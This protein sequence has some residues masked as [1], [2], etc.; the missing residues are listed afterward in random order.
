MNNPLFDDGFEG[1]PGS[2]NQPGFGLLLPPQTNQG[3][4][5]ANHDGPASG[6]M[7]H[8]GPTARVNH[9]NRANHGRMN[10]GNPSPG[11][12][13]NHGRGNS[14]PIHNNNRAN[15][16]MMNNHNN[17]SSPAMMNNHNNN[18]HR[19][20]PGM[21][22]NHNG[23][24]PGMNNNNMNQ[25]GMMNNH[26][27][28]NPGMV[29]NHNG[30]NHGMMNNHNNHNKHHRGNPGMMNN[31]NGGHPG[32]MNQN[33][34]NPGMMHNNNN[35]AHPGMMNNHNGGGGHPGMMN[36]HHNNSRRNSGMNHPNMR[37]G[38]NTRSP[39]VNQ[40]HTNPSI[41]NPSMLNQSNHNNTS[42]LNRSNQ[43]GFSSLHSNSNA[44]MSHHHSSSHHGGR[45]NPS[46]FQGGRP[47][48]S[49]HHG[50]GG[51]NPTLAQSSWMD[52]N[53]QN[54]SGYHMHH[55][56]FKKA[57]VDQF[58]R[59][60]FSSFDHDKNGVLDMHEFPQMCFAFFREL[61]TDPPSRSDIKY[62]MHIFDTDK[63]HH[64]SFPEFQNML[65]YLSGNKNEAKKSGI[66]GLG[67]PPNPTLAQS[68]WMDYNEQNWSGYKMHSYHYHFKRAQLEQ[69]GHAIFNRFDHDKNGVLDMHEFPQMCVAFFRELKT[70]PPSRSDIKYLMH[71]FDTNKD[72][73]ISYIEF[74]NM[75]L[76]LSGEKNEAKKSGIGLGL[77]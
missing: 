13:N 21:M 32:M 3:H 4:N 34:H 65:N 44:G 74:Q 40:G 62:L 58:A 30:P 9:N 50:G 71:I 5:N 61:G 46:H 24:H 20:N 38:V 68:N 25:S 16:G 18:N 15:P 77:D 36:N 59:N 56:N 33:R 26:N 49:G 60:I 75:L 23:G 12:M 47:N 48:A 19:G 51:L 73:H 52:Y 55:Y 66:G 41:V 69:Y 27:A 1:G 11:M 6:I 14:G 43:P 35:G 76:Y 39:M 64:I 42:L 2:H 8:N 17:G 53:K 67:G 31:H 54:W 57:K 28:G 70:D 72:H 63:D 37:M 7:I 10:Q 29:G 22:N 45:H